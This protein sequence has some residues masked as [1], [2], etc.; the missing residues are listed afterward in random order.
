MS[1][2]E[3]E[4]KGNFIRIVLVEITAVAKGPSSSR[5]VL[6][7]HALSGVLRS[8]DGQSISVISL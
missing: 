1:V 3:F 8:P 5:V 7:L 6:R 4:P 2:V